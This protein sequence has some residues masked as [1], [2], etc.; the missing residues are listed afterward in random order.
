MIVA[1]TLRRSV[2]AL[3]AWSAVF[4]GTT[5]AQQASRRT[6]ALPDHPRFT[7]QHFG[8]QFGLSVVTVNALAQDRDG[9]LWIATQT[10][11]YRYDGSRV[12][13]IN[14]AEQIVG[15]YIDELLIAPD[16]T[17]WVRGSHGLAHLVSG[18]FE[19]LS[20]PAEADGIRQRGQTFAVDRR[21]TAYVAVGD[22]I[23]CVTGDHPPA[24]HA[25]TAAHGLPGKPSAIVLGP[26]GAVWFTAGRRLAHFRPESVTFSVDSTL[27]LPDEDVAGL[28]FDGSRTL[29]LR[30]E[31]HLARIDPQRHRLTFDD[32]GVP[33][34]SPDVARPILDRAG[35]LLVPSVAGLV[36]RDHGHWQAITDDQGL[37]GND[38]QTALEDREGI[39]WVGGSGTGLDRV[40]GTRDWRAW[41]TAEGLPDNAIWATARDDDGRL[42]VAT[43]H[44]VAL[45]DQ[46]GHHWRVPA[47]THGFADHEIRQLERAGDGSI[48][49]LS[50]VDGI[51]RINPHTLVLSY[52][53]AF[54]GE[55]YIFEAAAPDGS[56]WATTTTRLVRF[57]PHA[58]S[59][60]P[61]NVQLPPG[62][63]GQLWRPAFAPNGAL[64]LTERGRVMRFA[65]HRWR[66]FS[67]ADG[68]LGK[69]V[70]SLAAIDQNDV[71]IGYDDVVEITHLR[72]DATGT[73]HTQQFP[74]DYSVVATDSK[75]R[76]WL[77]STDG[78]TIVA[79]SGA[80]TTLSHADG[81]VW[82]DISPTGVREEADGSYIIATSRG[83]ARYTPPRATGGLADA[84][85]SGVRLTS[86]ML[87][88]RERLG[89]R[90]TEVAH[91]QGA[92]SAYF[93]PLTLNNPDAI[94]CRYRLG[95]FE[96]TFTTTTNREAHYTALPPGDYLLTVQCRRG[97]SAWT[98]HAAMFRF[99]VLPAYWETWW[100]RCTM[101][102]LALLAV[103]G[104][105]R[106]RTRALEARRHV[107]QQAVADRNAELVEKN[108]E[109]REMSL[110]DPLTRV[111]NRRYVQETID[112][113]IA[114]LRRLRGGPHTHGVKPEHT[115]EIIF[116]MV[117]IDWFKSVNDV[118]GHAVGDRLIQLVAERLAGLMRASDVL[119][120]WGGEEFLLICR[121]TDRIGAQILGQRI[122][123][124][125]GATPFQIE[126]GIEL[127]K[128]CSVG[129]APFPWGGDDETGLSVDHVVQL[130]DHA[131]YLA[132]HGGRNQ[133]VGMLPS[134]L[135]MRTPGELRMEVL[136]TC[137]P[138]LVHIVRAFGS[139]HAATRVSDSAGGTPA[140]VATG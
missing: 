55:K 121:A 29:W 86:V 66:V 140:G 6:L 116:A 122:I 87:G 11:L 95:G 104:V 72:L 43:A 128:T 96:D 14:D 61:V 120:R 47:D 69:S 93:T 67:E 33:P 3:L 79:P 85:V 130:A 126:T 74:W 64:W 114:Q 102:A 81:L 52:S 50:P 125:I 71:W 39:I 16:S 132:K 9:F 139:R 77:S 28:V 108:R 26:D 8:E 48:W 46:T 15:H 109:L 44:G 133:S 12:Q 80:I 18:H 45:W 97:S 41:T 112:A 25:L 136:R 113:E 65:D 13:E 20:L 38:V 37:T 51:V 78:L 131:L 35:E 21:G 40:I 110:T 36:R 42:W 30:T 91:D 88:G 56:I 53:P 76:V 19:R 135:A 107:L 115:G 75:H 49:A 54:R 98:P 17:L 68:V 7:T 27:V 119:A 103:W 70:T 117:D 134:Q 62:E 60:V 100:A 138:E 31:T 118:H 73:P 106:L 10:G 92:L 24:F 94:S 124:E 84:T 34:A 83:L 23:I 4:A 32:A 137:P 57:D 129:W 22:V 105:V 99:S 127:R 59:P 90:K 101:A 5:R 89:A 2:V 82:D 58:P 111:R 1:R 123:D 63:P